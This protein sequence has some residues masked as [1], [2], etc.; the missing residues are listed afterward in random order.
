MDNDVIR[1]QREKRY[2]VIADVAGTQVDVCISVGFQS[3]VLLLFC[4]SL[5]ML[6][7]H[8]ALDVKRQSLDNDSGNVVPFFVLKRLRYRDDELLVLLG[9]GAVDDQRAVLV[10]VLD[11]LVVFQV[12]DLDVA[13][14]QRDQN[15]LAGNRVDRSDSRPVPFVDDAQLA[16][17]HI[18]QVDVHV[19]A[20][21]EQHAFSLAQFD[22]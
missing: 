17:L 6:V 9:K 11:A 19:F 15:V 13:L 5:S 18:N 22:R 2:L 7:Q 20:A 14:R 21:E 10:H 4:L 16:A 1:I 12:P 3:F 8:V